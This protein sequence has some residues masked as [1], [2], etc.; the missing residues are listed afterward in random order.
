MRYSAL[1]VLMCGLTGGVAMLAAAC[2]PTPASA[3]TA[4]P[5]ASVPT[6]APPAAASPAQKTGSP[7]AQSSPV[8]AASPVAKASPAAGIRADWEA[9]WNRVLA[10]AKQEGTVAVLGPAGAE[11]REALATP[12]QE[13]YGI[14]V[15]FSGGSNRDIVPRLR[16]ERDAGKFLWDVRVGGAIYE[17]FIPLQAL[18]PVPPALILPE[19]LEPRNWRSGGVEYLDPEKRVVVM[20]PFQRGTV[21]INPNLVKPGEIASYRDLLDP[22]WKGKIVIDDPRNTGPGEVTFAFMYLHPALGPDFVRAL[23][24]Q[25]PVVMRDFQQEVNAVAQGNYPI[26]IG[27]ADFIVEARMRQGLPITIVEP[28]DLKEGTDVH[29]ANGQAAL[30]NRAPHP[31]AAAVYLNWLL[32]KEG[33]TAFVKAAGY[34][35]GRTDVPTDHAPAW[36]VPKANAV[37]TYSP[38]TVEL[39]RTKVVPFMEEILGKG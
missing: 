32:S 26:L 28:D 27:T 3:P 18:D 25:E 1:K 9:E 8:Q 12:F 38:E 22:K 15:E 17:G 33:Q 39:I 37:K 29:P 21:F 23:I 14:T 10:A 16:A 13:K 4:P 35:S 31:N 24:G 7:V 36:R 19:V 34:V 2:A 20:T 11:V 5:P 6:A 30:M